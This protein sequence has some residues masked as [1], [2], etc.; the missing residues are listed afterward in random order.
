[1]ALNVTKS[2]ADPI[3]MRL[4]EELKSSLTDA[5]NKAGRS[6]NAEIRMR[7]EWS[8]EGGFDGQASDRMLANEVESLR[9]E[10]RSG[11]SEFRAEIDALSDRM[12]RLNRET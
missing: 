6:L 11:I 8:F 12:D 10:L 2:R 7:L 4:P 1:M 9:N 3:S 5:A